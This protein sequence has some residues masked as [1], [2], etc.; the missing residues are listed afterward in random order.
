MVG[1][2]VV[3]AAV[4]LLATLP[5]GARELAALDMVTIAGAL[6]SLAALYSA[7]SALTRAART[8]RRQS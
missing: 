5:R 3:L 6:L 8:S 1:R 2:N 7:Q 4:V